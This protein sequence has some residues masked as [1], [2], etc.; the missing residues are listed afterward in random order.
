MGKG[1]CSAQACRVLEGP[2]SR[3]GRARGH[4]GPVPQPQPGPGTG[5]GLCCSQRPATGGW[6]AIALRRRPWPAW[7]LCRSQPSRRGRAVRVPSSDACAGHAGAGGRAAGGRGLGMT[8]GTGPEGRLTENH[9]LGG[10]NCRNLFPP[11]SGGPVRTRHGLSLLPAQ[12]PAAGHL[13][14]PCL[15]LCLCLHMASVS[16]CPQSPLTPG[17]QSYGIRS[18]TRPSVT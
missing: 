17:S 15:A 5:R 9:R 7:P 18:P 4:P 12:R 6:G 16:V 8:L 1:V 2:H 14:S 11:G 3:H 13:G 10:G